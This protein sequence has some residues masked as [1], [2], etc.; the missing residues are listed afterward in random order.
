MDYKERFKLEFKE[1]SERIIKLD[2]MLKKYD[3]GTLDFTPTCS[4]ELLYRQLLSMEAYQ[5][6]LKE[7]AEVENINLEEE[8]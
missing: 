8:N 1:L 7:R 5:Y 6:I 4:Y 2:A 3:A